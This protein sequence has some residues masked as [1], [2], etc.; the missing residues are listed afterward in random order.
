MNQLENIIQQAYSGQFISINGYK[1]TYGEVSNYLVHA[2]ANY[3]KVHERSLAK[4]NEIKSSVTTV[5]IVRYAWFDPD[6]TEHNRKAGGRVQRKI[7]ETVKSNDPDLIEAFN[8]VEQSILNP[9]EVTNNFEGSNS[10]FELNGEVYLRNVLIE[11]KKVLT[12]G[13]YPVSCQS[14]V[15]A[16]VDWI[17]GQLPMSKYR[18]FK[19]ASTNCESLSASGESFIF[20]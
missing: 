3:S 9:R 1:N 6:G 5:D 11:S 14:R 13:K 8:K 20:N 10:S 2:D 16:L 4:L 18:T 15:S 7:N 19:L 12:E 17:K